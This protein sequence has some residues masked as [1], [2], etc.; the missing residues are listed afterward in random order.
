M[1]HWSETKWIEIGE[2]KRLA[3]LADERGRKGLTIPAWWFPVIR[4][5]YEYLKRQALKDG[6]RRSYRQYTTK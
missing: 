3:K 1:P 2:R 5:Y 6:D 4:D